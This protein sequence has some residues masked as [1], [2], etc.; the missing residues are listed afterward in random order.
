M[1]RHRTSMSR[2]SGPFE[3]RIQ[4]L[5]LPLRLKGPA[6]IIRPMRTP[7]MRTVLVASCVL[8]SI[9]APARAQRDTVAWVTRRDLAAG[10]AAIGATAA[11][12]PF[13]HRISDE[14]T[15]PGWGRGS[16]RQ[17]AAGDVAAFG[18]RGPFLVS[19]VALAVGSTIDMPF[20]TRLALHNVEAIA[21]GGGIAGLIR[22][23]TGRALPNVSAREQFS[24]GRGFH[25]DNGPFVSFP[26]GHTTAA[27]AMAATI[28]GE[29]KRAAPRLA[30]IVTPAMFTLA[31]A[32][33]VAR[34]AQ[35]DH[36]PTDLPLA[37]AIGTWSGNTVQA[38][39][40]HRGF[41]AKAL[42][43]IA[44]APG[45]GGRMYVGWS[46]LS[47]EVARR[48][49]RGTYPPDPPGASVDTRRK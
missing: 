48:T 39:S 20:L 9:A 7:R 5:P 4:I 24:F 14:F 8:S 46:L 2:L 23:F 41:F 18:G 30:P 28:S 13:D 26:S 43:G 49:D 1:L 27:F 21:L 25:D 22:G 10:A 6:A 11:L 45:P 35:R 31:T 36:W 19:G 37:M 38:H 29:V 16:E 3:A 17:R 32:V 34:V 33:G 15:E 40:G 42:S 44:V 47:S 12:A